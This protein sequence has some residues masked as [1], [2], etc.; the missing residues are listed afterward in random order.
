[1][2]ITSILVLYVVLWFL[3]LFVALPLRVRSQSED[4]SIVP[5]TPGSAPT[6][7]MIRAKLKWV[8]LVATLLWAALCAFILWGGVTVRDIDFWGRM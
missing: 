8:T 2:T 3:T 4:G 5:G 1:M 6:D 7:P